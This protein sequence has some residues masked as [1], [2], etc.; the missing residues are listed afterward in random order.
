M[1]SGPQTLTTKP[2]QDAH[3]GDAHQDHSA[4]HDRLRLKLKPKAPSTGYVD[5]GWWPRSRDLAAEL[6]ALVEVLSV[7]LGSVTRVAYTM[8]AWNSGPRRVEVD[9][10]VVR[11]EGFRT[12]DE[13][14][15]HLSGPDRTRISLLVVPPETAE[16]QAHEALMSASHRGNDDLPSAILGR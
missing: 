8:S 7:R 10:H 5:G 12:Q 16:E 1:T 3:Q 13:N 15:V 9:G 14:V 4:D 2:A 11:L 6:P